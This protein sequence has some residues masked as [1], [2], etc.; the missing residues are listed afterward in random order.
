MAMRS[1]TS[2]LASLKSSERTTKPTRRPSSERIGTP[3]FITIVVFFATGL[4]ISLELTL[5]FPLADSMAI[6]LAQ[7]G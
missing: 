6:F 1:G 7:Y 5:Q 2:A 3:D 4:F